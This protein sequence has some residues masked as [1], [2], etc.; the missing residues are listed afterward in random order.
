MAGLALN[1]GGYG[2]AG[3]ANLA[4]VPAQAGVSPGAPSITQRAFGIGTSQTE[5]GPSTAGY[6]TTALGIAGAAL[7][8][9][10]WW[11]LPR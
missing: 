6:G 1:V 4:S 10:L 2:S 3:A 8:C 11:T 9:W 5:G 7:L